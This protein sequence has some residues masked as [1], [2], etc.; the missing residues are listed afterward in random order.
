MSDCV[1]RA[2]NDGKRLLSFT[3]CK[4]PLNS[5]RGGVFCLLSSRNTTR[6]LANLFKSRKRSII[7]KIISKTVAIE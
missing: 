3:L 1:S 4:K 2:G 5:T 6:S 7:I